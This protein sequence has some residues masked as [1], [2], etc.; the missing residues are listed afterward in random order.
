MNDIDLLVPTGDAVRA[1]AVLTDDGWE[2]ANT[3]GVSLEAMVRVLHGVSFRRGEGE[4]IDLHWH[5]LEECC[6][7]GDDA[8]FWRS[9]HDFDFRGTDIHA[10]SP[11]DLLINVCVHG[12]RG[13]PGRVVRWVV[14]AARIL[15]CEG[16]GFNWDRVVAHSRQ[17]AVS[18]AMS[19]CLAYLRE[20]HLAIPDDAVRRLEVTRTG[21]VER[22]E[23]HVQDAP[24]TLPWAVARDLTRY[25]RLSRGRSVFERGAGLPVYL[26]DLW[27]LAH[28]WSAPAEGGRRVWRRARETRFNLRKPLAPD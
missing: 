9:A 16:A 6:R 23:E 4:E 18:L 26:Q 28:W 24:V 10:L 27:G 1:A 14:D 5:V 15:E 17:M 25:A 13:Y 21:R 2:R 3:Q 19:N 20:L 7:P 12:A 22:F 8:G 11:E